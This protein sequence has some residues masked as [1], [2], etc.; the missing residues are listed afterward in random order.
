MKGTE[1]RVWVDQ[2]D[3]S[4]ATSQVD[5]TFEVGEA[6]RT[7]LASGAQEFVPL[8]PKCTVAQNGYFEGVL[9][10]GFEAEMRTRFGAGQAVL[11]VVTQE[12]DA[13]CVCYVLPEATDYN[14]VFGAPVAGLV[15]LNGQWG[16]AAGAVRGLRVFDGTFDALEEGAVVDFGVGSTTG[17]QAFLHV[18]AITGTAVNALIRVQSSANQVDWAD[19][20]TFTLSTVGGY[21]LTLTGTVGRYVRLACANLGGATAIRCM[22]VVSLSA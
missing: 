4:S 7:S 21:R 10:N 15:T 16:T 19:E 6:E 20:G 8:L 5:V 1:M 14:M 18:A 9:T 22:G 3:F 12:S 11:T 2:F 17:G 13:N